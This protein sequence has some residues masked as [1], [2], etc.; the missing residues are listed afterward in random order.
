M[1]RA[2]ALKLTSAFVDG[3]QCSEVFFASSTQDFVVVVFAELHFLDG[4]LH[5]SVLLRGTPA[6]RR[7]CIIF[8]EEVPSLG[9]VE[10]EARLRSRVI[11][12]LAQDQRPRNQQI[13]MTFI[14]STIN[15]YSNRSRYRYQTSIQ[16]VCRVLEDG[17]R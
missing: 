12:E 11:G 6:T 2:V 13:E 14:L 10:A 4:D 8:V 16:N 17:K 9:I 7:G 3:H 1:L 5:A 15:G